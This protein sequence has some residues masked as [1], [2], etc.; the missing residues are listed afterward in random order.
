MIFNRKTK[1]EIKCPE[2]GGELF[3][4]DHNDCGVHF[5]CY[6]NNDHM[7]HEDDLVG[8]DK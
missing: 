7:F 1:K 8:D 4:H 3:G 5:H 6:D 2:C